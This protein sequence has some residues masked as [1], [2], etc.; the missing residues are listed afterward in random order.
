LKTLALFLAIASLGR[1]DT[2]LDVTSTLDVDPT[3]TG[4]ITRNGIASTWSSLKP[5]PGMND[6]TILRQYE[7]FT[8]DVP[9]YLGPV[10]WEFSLTQPSTTLFFLA[11]S[12]PFN[13]ANPG[14]NYL[15]DAGSSGSNTTFQ[16]TRASGADQVYL[17][18]HEVNA[19]A[20]LNQ[21]YRLVAN[22]YA[23]ASRSA[24]SAVPE[25]ASATLLLMGVGALFAR[26]R[27][28]SRA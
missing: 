19:G 24:L 28:S 21:P 9:T 3:Q 10:F 7:I 25:P 11:Y 1:A 27:F 5:F 22:A 18:V 17:V 4:R 8:V 6:T 20:G 16:V 12:A 26:R 23:D 2:I 14:A 13:P 15:G